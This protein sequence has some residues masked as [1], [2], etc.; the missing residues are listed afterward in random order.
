RARPE[1]SRWGVAKGGLATLA[2][3][4]CF[5][6]PL[7]QATGV[8][9]V[10]GAL[11]VTRR[12]T[13]R[14]M[15]EH[16]D[17]PLLLLFVG[18]FV[19]TDAVAGLPVVGEA[20]AGLQAAGADPNRLSLLAPFALLAS[21]TIGNVPTV[22]LLLALWPDLPAPTLQALALLSTL[23]GNLLLVGSL[24][25]LIV[26]ERAASVGARLGFLDHA[27]CGVPMTLASVVLAVVWLL[28][29]G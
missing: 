14:E 12:R 20:V 9:I 27:R 21:N 29:I 17:W 2:L 16:V 22:V 26:A 13:T 24:A 10:A 6:L 1:F 7:P 15:L 11:L 19:I 5:A 18:L 4:A 28:L 8:L 23:A 25:N 3:L